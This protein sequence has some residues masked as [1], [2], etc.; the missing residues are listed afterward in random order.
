MTNSLTGTVHSKLFWKG[1]EEEDGFSA[2]MQRREKTAQKW[3]YYQTSIKGPL[4]FSDS[5]SVYI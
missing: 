2:E 4:L 3:S 5:D 1:N